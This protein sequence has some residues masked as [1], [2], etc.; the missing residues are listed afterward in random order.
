MTYLQPHDFEAQIASLTAKPT[1]LALSFLT[2]CEHT[3]SRL[4][5]DI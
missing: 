5:K 2:S 4:N 3:Q 1:F